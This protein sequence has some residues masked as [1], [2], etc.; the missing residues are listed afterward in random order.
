MGIV[1]WTDKRHPVADIHFEGSGADRHGVI[2]RLF[3]FVRTTKLPKS[4]REPS[5]IER[6]V[7][8]L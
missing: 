1:F 4:C 8:P 3:G 7:T 5:I 6:V 2:K